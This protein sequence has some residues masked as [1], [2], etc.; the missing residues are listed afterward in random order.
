VGLVGLGVGTVFGA[1]AISDH[2]SAKCNAQN[3]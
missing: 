3:V 2:D 1:M